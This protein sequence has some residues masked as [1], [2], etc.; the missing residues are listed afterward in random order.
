M[1]REVKRSIMDLQN[2]VLEE[3][4]LSGAEWRP[5]L[6]VFDEAVGGE[7]TELARESY[8]AGHAAAAE[9]AGAA[10]LP[11]A[12]APAEAGIG[13]EFA[14]ALEHAV[15]AAFER[16]AGTDG[17]RKIGAAVSRV[18]RGWRTDEAERRVRF[19]AHRAYHD[20]ALTGFALLGVEA[21]TAVAP[22][23]PCG[24]CAAGSGAVWAP[25]GEPPDGM[26]VPPAGLGCDD[27]VVPAR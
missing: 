9:L 4:R 26:E 22:G 2:R 17:P 13:A 7:L 15:E 18:F 14:A 27:T 3:L 20:G 21:V 10:A 24:A 25:D 23:R 1:L 12:E 11:P 16:A 19:L 8:L 6:P 5:E